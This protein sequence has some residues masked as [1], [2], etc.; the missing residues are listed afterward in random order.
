[1]ITLETCCR[2]V[3]VQ[4]EHERICLGFARAN[5]EKIDSIIVQEAVAIFSTCNWGYSKFSTAITKAMFFDVTSMEKERMDFPSIEITFKSNFDVVCTKSGYP[6][7]K[8]TVAW[9]RRNSAHN[10][11]VLEIPTL[12]CLSWRNRHKWLTKLL[13]IF[14]AETTTFDSIV[15]DGWTRKGKEPSN[16]SECWLILKK[17]WRKFTAIVFF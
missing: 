5:K 11:D 14:P 17:L 7:G 13:L 8:L 3:S 4:Q 15:D 12:K 1:M 10:L 9:H 16:L 2:R 6:A